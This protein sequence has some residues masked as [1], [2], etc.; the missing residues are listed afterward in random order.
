MGTS[1]G[2]RAYAIIGQGMI[3]LII[4]E[5]RLEELRVFLEEAVAQKFYELQGGQIE[6][7]KLLWLATQERSHSRTRKV[8]S[9]YREGANRAGAHALGALFRR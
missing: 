9:R 5:S 8:L 4:E 3:S 2:P 6:M 7:Q 1:L